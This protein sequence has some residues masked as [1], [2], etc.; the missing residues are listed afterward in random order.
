MSSPYT[1]TMEFDSIDK[2]KEFLDKRTREISAELAEI[3][4]KLEVISSMVEAKRR[5]MSLFK[6]QTPGEPPK[7]GVKITEDTTLYIDPPPEVLS[8]IYEN[9]NNVLNKKLNAYRNL[10][11]AVAQIPSSN[12]PINITLVLENDFPKYLLI[13][14]K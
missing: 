3:I 11:N 1:V 14:P 2:L 7:E 8:D 5:L 9:L 13:K 4:K 6:V 10:K 12:V